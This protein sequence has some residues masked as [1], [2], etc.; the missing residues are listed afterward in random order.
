MRSLISAKTLKRIKFKTDNITNDVIVSPLITNL[1]FTKI[2]E[3]FIKAI[4]T[5]GSNER[6]EK[7]KL[8]T[9]YIELLEAIADFRIGVTYVTGCSQLGK[10]L[11]HINLNCYCVEELGLNSLW[12]YDFEASL[13]IQVP[14]NFRPVIE[15]WLIN[16][17]KI[18]GR[19]A[20]NNKIYQ[21]GAATAQF[22]YVSTTSKKNSNKQQLAAA[23]GVA[24]GVARDI[25][26]KE[27]RSQYPLGAADPLNRRLDASRVVT[28]PH[29]E[30]GTPGGGAG[31]EAEIKL[32]DHYFYP[33][34]ECSHCQSKL[35]LNPKGC[36][37]QEIKINHPVLGEKIAY[38]SESG[39]PVQWFCKDKNDPVNTAYFG[40]PKCDKEIDKEARGKAWYQCLYKQITLREYLDTLPEKELS[41][42]R[43]KI[44]LCISPLLRIEVTNTAAEI[45]EEGLST[46]NTADWQQQRL[47][48]ESEQ[49]I[50]KI[51]LELLQAA[52]GAP[53][54]DR[55]HDVRIAGCDAGTGA[56]WLWIMDCYLPENAVNLPIEKIIEQTVR[57]VIF[58]Q[59]IT[60]TKLA[61][62]ALKID[63]GLIDNQ[64]DRDWATHFVNSHSSFEMADQK[65]GLRDAVQEILVDDGG[66][67][68]PC[69]NIRNEK[70]LKSV[71]NG[72][73]LTQD[74]YPLYRLPASWDKYK[75]N[76]KSDRN[77]FKHLMAMSYDPYSG[78]WIRPAN[79]VDDI[80]HAAMFA[81]AAFYLWLTQKW[82][83][84]D[85]ISMSVAPTSATKYASPYGF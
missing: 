77:P 36:L 59:G 56:H 54:P 22:T 29:R 33:H 5:K 43:L 64:P 75:N 57:K 34:F 17:N 6:K 80:Y 9:W 13:D 73:V 1:D 63:Y 18:N 30:L 79:H 28:K 60:K 24:V 61:E 83:I 23:G 31:I 85:G 51:T 10:T 26:F 49:G 52:T 35:P 41:S 74:G 47:G 37:L 72:F 46:G 44:G 16:A 82:N 27:E 3:N 78:K 11:S 39:R 20:R 4:Q 50:N 71:L 48:L 55:K 67:K 45:I 62:M 19:G 81:E 21:V 32:A 66:I 14:S 2:R 7:I 70:F 25:L 53:V 68:S 15:K 76:L 58:G 8:T 42:K 40:C 84:D 69:W 65:A 38:L 12:S